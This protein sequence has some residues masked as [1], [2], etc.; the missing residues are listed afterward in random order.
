MTVAD[1]LDETSVLALIT[2]IVIDIRID[3]PFS[4]SFVNDNPELMIFIY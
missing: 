1:I 3:D 4:F 2:V